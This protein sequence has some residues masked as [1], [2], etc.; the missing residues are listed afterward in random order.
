MR[1]SFAQ[2]QDLG[3]APEWLQL[4]G[5]HVQAGL[6]EGVYQA[7]VL[8]VARYGAVGYE[9][10]FGSLMPGGPPT[11]P[12]TLFDLASLTK[13]CVAAALLTLVEDGKLSLT[14]SVAEILPEARG[15]A[16]APVTMKQLATHTAGLPAWKP[17]HEAGSTVERQIAEILR[18]PLQH[19]AGTRYEY[20]DLGYILLGGIIARASGMELNRYLH[21]RIFAPLGMEDTGYRPPTALHGRIAPTAHSNLRPGAMLIGE[22]HDENA[23]ASGGVS[24]HAGLFGTAPDLAVFANALLDHGDGP[25]L[26][27]LPSLRLV[28]TNQ[29]PPEIGGH[30]IGWFTPPNPLLS[31]GD[32]LSEETFGHTGFTGTLIVCDPA[33]DLVVILLTNRVMAGR[34]GR[35]I[36]QVRQRVLNAVASAVRTGRRRG[37]FQPS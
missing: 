1:L 14:Q 21:E 11:Q 23:S 30:S 29:I 31:R 19:P 12:D 9:A 22:V 34:D 37:A 26:L 4:A 33:F 20:S 10:A 5:V 3:L 17:L 25:R 6:D 36:R 2:P 7:A 15:T 13:P 32:L 28:Q 16:I 27:S 24:G 18:T 35:G 8:L